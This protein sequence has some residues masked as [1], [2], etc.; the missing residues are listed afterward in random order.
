MSGAWRSQLCLSGF[1]NVWNGSSW[2]C[3]S[4]W[5]AFPGGHESHLQRISPGSIPKYATLQ[6]HALRVFARFACFVRL[7][8]CS[9]IFSPKTSDG[10][11]KRLCRLRRSQL[12]I[13]FAADG[14]YWSIYRNHRHDD[15]VGALRNWIR[16]DAADAGCGFLCCRRVSYWILGDRL[17]S[18]VFTDSPSAHQ[19]SRSVD[20]SLCGVSDSHLFHKS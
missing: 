13:S 16:T 20:A 8:R 4:P 11:R 6:N 9:D 17:F 3:I 12:G 5:F 7:Y 1:L 2:K 19:R 15:F 14:S 18:V 10:R